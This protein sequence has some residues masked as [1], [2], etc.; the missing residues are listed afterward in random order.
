MLKEILHGY[1]W[2]GQKLQ[3]FKANSI[4]PQVA[5][6]ETENEFTKK[7]FH[8]PEC[9]PICGEKTVIHQ[10]NNSEVLF[11]DNP[12]CSGKILN[13]FKHFVGKKG[14][15]IKG[16]S[17][18]TLSKLIDWGWLNTYKDIFLLYQHREEWIN[19]AGFGTAS[20]DKILKAIEETKE[21][22]TMEKIIAAAGIPEIGSRVAKELAKYYKT[23]ADFRTETDFTKYEGIGEVMNNNIL[24]FDY[25]NLNLD[26][27]INL[28][29]KVKDKEEKEE[30]IIT[31]NNSSLEGKVFCITGSLNKNGVFKT[32]AVLQND[33]ESKGGKVVSSM[34]NKVNYLINNDSTSQ[35]AKNKAAIAAG[36]PIITEEEYL[37]M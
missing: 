34:S 16:I 37:K 20:V 25:D 21:N 11:C 17:E 5:S 29:L 7:Y 2:E 8:Y 24:T 22:V 36:I 12:N 13:L 14:L 31:N 6:A 27:T 10:D 9:C 1:G 18:A 33:I 23:W 26:Y 30:N 28:F 4:I 3:I 19:K 15:D 32:R 35:S